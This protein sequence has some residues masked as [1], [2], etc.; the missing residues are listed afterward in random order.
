MPRTCLDFRRRTI[1][2]LETP[3][4]GNPYRSC[5]PFAAASYPARRNPYAPSPDSPSA[6]A[7][8]PATV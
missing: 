7:L 6:S 1:L 5:T 8:S 4:T 2:Y 3:S